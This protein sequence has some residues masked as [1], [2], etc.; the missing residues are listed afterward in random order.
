MFPELYLA[1]LAGDQNSPAL[2]AAGRFASVALPD[3]N[4]FAIFP[5]RG[6]RMRYYTYLKS[7]DASAVVAE[8]A[9]FKIHVN[10]RLM[11]VLGNGE[12]VLCRCSTR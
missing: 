10:G 6:Y 4:I 7:F 1:V 11:R 5:M 9:T 8:E 3:I 2:L 12:L